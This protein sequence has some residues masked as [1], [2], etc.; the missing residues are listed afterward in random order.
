M[1]FRINNNL[2]ISGAAALLLMV[3]AV[4]DDLAGMTA[5]KSGDYKAAYYEWK[6]LS[7]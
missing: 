6:P 3:P 2:W 5:F 1:S 4:A 7:G